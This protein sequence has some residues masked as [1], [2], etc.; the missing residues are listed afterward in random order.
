MDSWG[1]GKLEN[2]RAVP[3]VVDGFSVRT[4][5]ADRRLG[6]AYHCKVNYRGT[7]G[8][9]GGIRYDL[10]TSDNV[11]L[12]LGRSM[13]APAFQYPRQTITDQVEQGRFASVRLSNASDGYEFELYDEE[14]DNQ[15][16]GSKFEYYIP[17]VPAQ[18]D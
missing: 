14:F 3:G 6:R 10:A 2:I 13:G 16:P 12:A 1:R 9:T 7:L 4:T 18:T 17:I 15:D 8:L 11:A 5:G